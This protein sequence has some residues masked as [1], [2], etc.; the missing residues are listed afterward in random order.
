MATYLEKLICLTNNAE[1]M[2]YYSVDSEGKTWTNPHDGLKWNAQL[3][4]R[5]KPTRQEIEAVT[6]EEVIAWQEAQRKQGRD[7]QYK[8]DLSLK[9]A[10]VTYKKSNPNSTFSDYLDYLESI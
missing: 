9:A 2:A 10:F 6:D 3:A 1:G 5:P 8:D 4:G 7:E